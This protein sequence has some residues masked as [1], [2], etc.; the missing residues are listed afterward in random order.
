M[1]EP[2]GR[3]PLRI[4]RCIR[5]V[6]EDA[7]DPAEVRAWMRAAQDGAP[8]GVL[9][10]V[11]ATDEQGSLVG[12]RMVH[13]VSASKHAYLLPLTRDLGADE[14]QAVV[15]AMAARAP[16]L[17][18]DVETDDVRIEPRERETIVVSDEKH[19]ALCAALAKSR[20]AAWM[21]ERLDAGWRFGTAFSAREKTSPLL[22]PWEQLPDRFRQPDMDAPQ[23]LL[24]LV[25]AQGFAV[26]PS[27]DLDR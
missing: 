1:A 6:A 10:T 13:Q 9:A 27:D 4:D 8:S 5:L 20:H 19:L 21:R 26:I 2:T 15:Q 22:R 16:K 18:F 3:K 7:L 24:D 25:R 14:V 11:Q 17:D 23:A 12:I